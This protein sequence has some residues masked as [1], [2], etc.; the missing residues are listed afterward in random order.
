MTIFY[1]LARI[2]LCCFILSLLPSLTFAEIADGTGIAQLDKQQGTSASSYAYDL[3][4]AQFTARNQSEANAGRQLVDIEVRA[5]GSSERYNAIWYP[6]SGTVYRLIQGTTTDWEAFFTAMEPKNGRWLDV[7]VD[8]FSGT[9]RYSALFYEDG[10]D[11]GYALRTTNTD[12]QFQGYLQEYF[13]SGMAIID[14]EAYLDAGNNIR[15]AGVWVK[16]PNQ[17]RTTLYYGLQSDELSDLLRPLAGRVVDFERYYSPLHSEDRYALIIAMYGDGNWSL[18]R[19]FDGPGI[20]AKHTEIADATTHMIDIESWDTSAGVRYGAVWGDNYASLRELPAVPANSDAENLNPTLTNLMSSFEGNNSSSGKFGFYAK[21]V[22]TN[23]SLG[24]REDEPF[25]LAS[26]AKVAV[27]IKFWLEVQR[28]HLNQNTQIPY[29]NANNSRDPWF[30]DERPAPGFDSGDFGQSFSLERFDRGMMQVSD[31]GAT[32]ALVDHA[33]FGLSTDTQDLNEWLAGIAGVGQGWGQVT[34]IQ[35][36]DRTILWQGQVMEHPNDRSYFL[37]PPWVFEPL[38]R[39]GSDTW[40]DLE[41][42]LGTTN[43]PDF[44]RNI[45]H[46][47]YYNMGLNSAT[48]NAFANLLEKLV[49]GDLL[50]AANTTEALSRMTEGTGLD[51]ASGFPAHVTVRA[52]GGL[53]G[54]ES[55]PSSNNAIFI[56]GPDAI[57]VSAL[58]KDNTRSSSTIRNTFMSPLGLEVLE[59]L[60]ADL[61]TCTNST[62]SFS[63]GTVQAGAPFSVTCAVANRGGGDATAFDV[64]F[65]A[66]ANDIIT[67]QDY[68]LGSVRISN[69]AGGASQN[70]TLDTTIALRLPAGTY[71][72]GWIIDSNKTDFNV[73]EVGEF[74]ESTASNVGYKS[75]QSLTVEA[76]PIYSFYIPWIAR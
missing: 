72:V 7:E 36:V 53:K 67:P 23:Q 27:H 33:A 61:E 44:N 21:N 29:T 1:R 49:Q 63:P 4:T 3:T 58:T 40:G 66:S 31:N 2:T 64:S 74:D 60:A 50:N 37:I 68:L 46:A 55:N 75:N 70:V 22:R 32:S 17:P 30:V 16:D 39:T 43:F 42:L 11:Y 8:Y 10:D 5:D 76:V 13:D 45:G 62:S 71:N 9:K 35:E 56:I 6:V 18:W 59:E 38:W 26:S 15:Y 73:G 28:G 24:Y 57:V 20:D 41:N 14:F 47:R 48:P 54:G 19:N 65:Y 34:S 12:E 25:Y 52:K 51:N 69:L